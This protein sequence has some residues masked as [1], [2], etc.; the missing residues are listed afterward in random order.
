MRKNLE[1]FAK[2]EKILMLALDHRESFA[3]LLSPEDPNSVSLQSAIDAKKEIIDSL[4]TSFTGVLIDKEYGLPAYTDHLKPFLLPLEKSGYTNDLGERITEL[5]FSP[6]DLKELGASGVKLLLYFNPDV[7]S[8]SRQISTARRALEES[9]L[10]E[11][12]L[13]LEI[14]V[15]RED[16]GDDLHG[17]E[18]DLVL[19]SLRVLYENEIVPDVWKLEFPG[20]LEGCQKVSEIVGDTP[21]I[22]LTKGSTFDIFCE[23]LKQ[24][25]E[26]GASGFL[27]GRALWQDLFRMNEGKEQFLQQTLPERFRTISDIALTVHAN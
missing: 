13:F 25:V 19:R 21:W 7:K 18:E 10:A 26:A 3:K 22:L 24:A 23:E 15:Y 27:A 17:E 2:D 5:E 12:P 8:A 6:L 4:K 1:V 14:R 20:S 9:R 11:L 16:S